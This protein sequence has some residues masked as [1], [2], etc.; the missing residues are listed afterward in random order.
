M[1]DAL[2][3]TASSEMADPMNASRVESKVL[4]WP[5]RI[6]QARVLA[7]L[8]RGMLSV[9]VLCAAVTLVLYQLNDSWERAL[10]GDVA[11]LI[12]SL[13]FA[14]AGYLITTRAPGNALGWILL[15]SGVSAPITSLGEEYAVY[16][17]RIDPGSLPGGEVAAWISSWTWI[18]VV[19]LP[20]LFLPLL[21]PDGHLLS[22][23]WRPVLW[24]AATLIALYLLVAAFA[25]GD[26]GGQVALDNPFGIAVVGQ[27]EAPIR[28]S[29][30]MAAPFLLL[31]AVAAAAVRFWRSRGDERLQ[32]K[33]FAYGVGAMAILSML[34]GPFGGSGNMLAGVGLALL[35]V[36]ISVAI[37]KYRLYDIDLV[38]NRTLVFSALTIILFGIYLAIAM[39]AGALV[40]SRLPSVSVLAATGVVALLFSPLHDRL[41]YAVNRL[42]YGQRDEPYAVLSHL[43]RRV[44]ST[45]SPAIVLTTVVDTVSQTLRL[46]YVA[47]ALR[48]DDQLM[49][50]AERGRNDGTKMVELQLVYGS[51]AVGVLRFCVHGSDTALRTADRTL[52]EDIAR[53]IGPAAHAVRLTRELKRSTD[54]LQVTRQRLV[55]AR[56]EERRRLRRDLHDGL[57]P[58]LAS[59]SLKL[60]ATRRLMGREPHAADA[61]LSELDADIETTI[62]DIRRLVY[63]LR[64]PALDDLGLIGAIREHIAHLNLSP[65]N[66]SLDMTLSVPDKLPSIPAAVEVAAY[67]IAKEATANVSRHAGARTCHIRLSLE[68]ETLDLTIEDDGRGIPSQR[69]R[70]VGLLSMRE[71]AQELG[72]TL[73]VESQKGV[74]T[75]ITARLPLGR[76]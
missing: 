24:L 12:S 53:Q 68:D 75:K 13:G 40:D 33:W 64:P 37:L 57:G 69:P 50:V 4:T 55:T 59:V 44:Q 74:G 25:T 16:T 18:S 52:L 67:R 28:D 72:G 63:G 3:P 60:G 29:L 34:N 49:T 1:Y 42:M 61:L 43:G 10:R 45:L 38:I 66:R 6:S 7:V 35:P 36:A 22:A 46:P 8:A 70:G 30:E 76:G 21:F 23:R 26:L 62:G 15:V 58:A 14:V 48:Q 31:A 19:L 5:A 11:T 56:E 20:A 39:G 9:W 27:V 51:E 47:I 17:L 71:R 41:Q 32:M 2:R 73:Q 54:H 65:P